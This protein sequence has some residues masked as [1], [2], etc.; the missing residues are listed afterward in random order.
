MSSTRQ[1]QE[2]LLAAQKGDTKPRPTSFVDMGHKLDLTPGLGKVTAFTLF[3]N[4]GT[5]DEL[6]AIKGDQVPCSLPIT[7]GGGGLQW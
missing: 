1:I 2:R 3:V 4:D 6:F 7:S 5:C